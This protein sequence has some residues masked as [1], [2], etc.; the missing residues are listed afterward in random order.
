V[1]RDDGV[2][3]KFATPA[4]PRWVRGLFDD[5]VTH[6]L[7]VP[8]VGPVE[9]DMSDKPRYLRKLPDINV[10]EKAALTKVSRQRAEALFVLDQQ[11]GVVLQ[12]LQRLGEYDDTVVAFTSDNGYY[13]GEHRKR[14]GKIL[15]HE[16]S[17][18]VPVPDRRPGHQARQAVRPDHLDR[19]GAD[20]RRLRRPERHARRGRGLARAHDREGRPGLEP[21][22]RDRGPDG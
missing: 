19:P 18:R 2:L 17:L 12:R 20:V 3:G 22:G 11:I 6:P 16:P 1:L 9:S 10:E 14:V 8:P 21:A 4:R 7:G 15:A 5:Q 13:L